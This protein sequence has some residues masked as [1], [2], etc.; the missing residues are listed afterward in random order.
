MRG[1]LQW[2][3]SIVQVMEVSAISDGAFVNLPYRS[4]TLITAQLSLACML[5]RQPCLIFN[6]ICQVEQHKGPTIAMDIIFCN[7]RGTW[8]TQIQSNLCAIIDVMIVHDVLVLNTQ[9]LCVMGA[10]CE[11]L[12]T[13]PK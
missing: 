8:S 5:H 3:H 13:M 10:H 11:N 2:F 9:R 7:Y 1:E 12:H 6:D 4:A